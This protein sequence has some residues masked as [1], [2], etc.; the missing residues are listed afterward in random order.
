MIIQIIR[1]KNFLNIQLKKLPMP[2]TGPYLVVEGYGVK[3][4]VSGKGNVPINTGG[5]TLE[6]K[7]FIEIHLKEL[8]EETTLSKNKFCQRAEIQRSQLN[9]YLNNTI[10]R[11]DTDVLVRICHT[12]NCSIA[13][14]LEYKPEE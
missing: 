2:I 1:K 14:L 10:T 4:A 11:L 5:I 8:L 6:G 12:L 7:G 13:D 3:N 9:G